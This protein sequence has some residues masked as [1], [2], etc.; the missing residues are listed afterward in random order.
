MKLTKWP[1]AMDQDWWAEA[2]AKTADS[3]QRAC[4]E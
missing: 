2:T 1:V 4:E 3:R